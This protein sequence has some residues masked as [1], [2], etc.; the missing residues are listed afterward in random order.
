M[1]SL[2][3]HLPPARLTKAKELLIEARKL[4][5]PDGAFP[6]PADEQDVVLELGNLWYNRYLLLGDTVRCVPL[7]CYDLGMFSCGLL[8]ACQLLSRVCEAEKCEIWSI[9]TRNRMSQQQIQ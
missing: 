5:G 9:P 2:P 7:L 8:S 6:S 4:V 1:P 3:T